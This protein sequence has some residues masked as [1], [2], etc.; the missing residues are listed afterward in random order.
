MREQKGFSNNPTL[1][2]V[3]R[4]GSFINDAE[5]TPSFGFSQRAVLTDRTKRRK[6]GLPPERRIP[7]L[8]DPAATR[9]NFIRHD[10]NWVASDITLTT[11]ADQVPIAPGYKISETT[12]N[13]RRT[14]RFV[15][16]APILQFFSMQSA[17]YVV[18]TVPYKG[19]AISV[20]YDSQHPWNVDR[21]ITTG[22]AGLDYDQANPRPISVPAVVRSR[23]SL[24][25]RAASPSRF[26]APCR[27]R[28][29]WCSSPTPA[30]PK[31][32]TW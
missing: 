2:R 8:G 16:E 21:M 25:S 32:S 23:S 31:R 5:A 27:G 4:N 6:Y 18:K 20:Y 3:V 7:K 24:L 9:F 14:A 29:D 13:G 26:R 11:D 28:R 17:R 30:T 1:T 12:T 22:E 10:S 19:V 15:T